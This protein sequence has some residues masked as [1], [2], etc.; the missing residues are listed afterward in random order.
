MEYYHQHFLWRVG[1]R[2][3]TM[4][5]VDD[6]TSIHS[7]GRLV[8]FYVE[9]DLYH[10]LAGKDPL[11]S[12]GEV[13]TPINNGTPPL[14]TIPDHYLPSKSTLSPPILRPCMLAHKPMRRPSPLTSNKRDSSEPN[15]HNVGSRFDILIATNPM[16]TTITDGGELALHVGDTP[17]L[18]T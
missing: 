16:I 15:I 3:G 4:L 2:L 1:N 10:Q 13:A 7:R 8:R 6:L 14:P 18:H 11:P 9:L 17:S 5:K 12:V